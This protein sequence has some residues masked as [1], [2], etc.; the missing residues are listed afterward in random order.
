MRF[1]KMLGGSKRAIQTGMAR[2]VK[3][4][5]S[6]YYAAG[7]NI[8]SFYP[9]ERDAETGEYQILTASGIGHS[10]DPKTLKGIKRVFIPTT[11]ELD[12]NGN[13][14][15][16]PDEVMHMS[17][18][19]ALILSGQ[20]QDGVN[21]INDNPNTTA[22]VKKTALAALETEYFGK[23]EEG[24][25]YKTGGKQP[26]IGRITFKT[27]VTQ[28]SVKLDENEEIKPAT[29]KMVTQ[30]LSTT[31]LEELQQALRKL[32]LREKK[33]KKHIEDNNIQLADYNDEQLIVMGE[34]YKWLEVGYEF[35]EKGTKQTL[36]KTTPK[37]VDPDIGLM[38]KDSSKFKRY[39][40]P[41]LAALPK[42]IEDAYRNSKD[43]A[44]ANIA[45][46]KSIFAVYV[47]TES[48][49]INSIVDPD[50]IEF[51][52]K[53]VES[54][55]LFANGEYKNLQLDQ[56][57]A[58][59]AKAKSAEALKEEIKKSKEAGDS[60]ADAGINETGVDS[61]DEDDLKL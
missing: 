7:D 13:V 14:I 42:N 11:M 4:G 26:V 41:N 8:R 61:E 2:K 55:K 12:E 59:E 37:Y 46:L 60:E 15:G 32:E 10:V 30:N 23:E 31:K 48:H 38:A 35:P 56:V 44:E 53:N 24:S 3:E 45:Q 47:A 34:G 25:E 17:K 58:E 6:K 28:F 20:Y 43:F 19:A 50:A 27:E 57:D 29:G 49:V 39:V 51:A 1:Q 5:W 33:I 21:K 52:Q 36:G 40:E 54:V 9:L 18:V 16:E 22:A